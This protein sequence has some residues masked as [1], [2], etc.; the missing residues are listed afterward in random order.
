MT[1]SRE[2]LQT[3]PFPL[4][5][6]DTAEFLERHLPTGWNRPQTEADMQMFARWSAFCDLAIRG[7]KTARNSAV[8]HRFNSDLPAINAFIVAR[9]SFPKDGVQEAMQK[10]GAAKRAFDYLAGRHVRLQGAD[11]V[12]ARNLVEFFDK[13]VLPMLALEPSG[14]G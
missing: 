7:Y 2:I 13:Q 9:Y 8:T 6:N 1:L 5:I 11:Q 12:E 3:A 4:P 10:V 14:S